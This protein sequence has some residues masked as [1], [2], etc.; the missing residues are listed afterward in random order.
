MPAD[1]PGQ[2]L[3]E[4]FPEHHGSHFGTLSILTSQLPGSFEYCPLHGT[5][6]SHTSYPGAAAPVATLP[7]IN[8]NLK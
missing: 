1:M 7:C 2:W 3:S 5:D 6:V 8:V 4:Q